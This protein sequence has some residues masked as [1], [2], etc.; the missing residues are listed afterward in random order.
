MGLLQAGVA[1]ETIISDVIARGQ[2]EAGVAWQKAQWSVTKEHRATSISESALHAVVARAM[3]AKGIPDA[4]S[5]GKVAVICTEGEWHT[6]GA[7]MASE[8]LR[9]RGADVTLVAPSVPATDVAEFMPEAGV[10]IAAISTSMPLSLFGSWRS[11]SA[12]RALGMTIVCGGRGFGPAGGWG[13][14][15]GADHWAESFAAG[16]DLVLSAKDQTAPPATRACRGSTAN[17]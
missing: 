12:L 15:L 6:L 11:I 10:S 13:L 7:R 14:A 1:P 5:A 8:T 9:L 2:Y 17:R 16:A 4:G 3:Q